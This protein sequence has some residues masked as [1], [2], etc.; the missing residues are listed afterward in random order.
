MAKLKREDILEELR[1]ICEQVGYTLRFE[2][3]DFVGGAC[4]LHKE[5]VLV[6]NTRSSIERKIAVIVRAL[7]E[8]GVEGVYLKP[9]IRELIEAELGH[10]P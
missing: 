8:I 1:R 3:G 9:A 6:V 10:K 4:I 5:R 7:A 2:R